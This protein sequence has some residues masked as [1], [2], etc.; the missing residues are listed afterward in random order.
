MFIALVYMSIG[1]FSK[2][3]ARVVYA[4]LCRMRNAAYN[5]N[6]PNK[7][8]HCIFLLGAMKQVHGEF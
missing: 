1:R 4:E 8:A 7:Y 3:Q 5:D 2:E 6:D